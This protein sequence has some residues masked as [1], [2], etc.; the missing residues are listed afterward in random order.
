MSKRQAAKQ[1]L[2]PFITLRDR[3]KNENMSNPILGC[4][5]VFTPQQ[6]DEIAEHVKLLSSLYYGL[7]VADLRKVVLNMLSSTISK[8]IL[9]KAAKQPDWIGYK[10]LGDATLQFLYAKL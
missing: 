1:Y 6:E 2:I 7:T 8:T 4:K 5:P 10:A 9:I 3:L